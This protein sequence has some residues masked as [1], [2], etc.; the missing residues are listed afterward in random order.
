ML[1]CILKNGKIEIAEKEKPRASN[2]SAVIKVKA[3]SICG[4]DLRTYK[5][6]S[7]KIR[8]GV[9]IGHEVCGEITEI[10][11]NTEGFAK[12]D[13]VTVTPA[14]GCGTCCVCRKGYSN[15]CDNLQ[16]LG[17][18]FDGSFAEYMEIP[19]RFFANGH[20]NHVD[21]SV[22]PEQAA[23]AEPVACAI[24]A[25]DFLNIQDGDYV[26]IFGSGF[27]GCIHAE[28]AMAQKASKVI[29][30]EPNSDRLK[31]ASKYIPS[32]YGITGN[33]V[34]AS[35]RKITDGRGADVVIVACS[36]GAAQEDA[37]KIIAKRGRISL[38]GGLPGE[39][40]GFIDSNIIHYK[41]LG[42][43]GAHA[44]TA[45]QNRK[46][47]EWLAEGKIDTGKYIAG[48]Y[49]LHNIMEAF[50]DLDEKGIMKAVIVDEGIASVTEKSGDFGSG[51]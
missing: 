27:I 48:K 24:N 20:V 23:L 26:A 18:Q 12:G 3:A 41:E 46:A 8:E 47:L 10:G 51:K 29:M 2:D 5:F 7:N 35:V 42:V 49:P 50:K 45:V 31:I 30:I 38:F 37:Q 40:K 21:P 43:F 13:C 34:E 22:R 36:V 25:Q 44:S 16:T 14:L 17:Y 32:V 11:R 6:G 39:G 33:D 1:A 9:T 19:A 4:T 28:L 15:M